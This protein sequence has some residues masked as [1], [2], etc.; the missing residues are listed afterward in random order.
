MVDPNY[1]WSESFAK[2]AQ[3][4]YIVEIPAD[5][6]ALLTEAQSVSEFVLRAQN[7]M[8]NRSNP[9]VVEVLSNIQR[10]LT[11]MDQTA[12]VEVLQQSPDKVVSPT[13]RNRT[14]GYKCES[15]VQ[16]CQLLS[17]YL[18]QKRRAVANTASG[19]G[20]IET[21]NESESL[22]L[23]L[24][25][26]LDIDSGCEFRIFIIGVHIHGEFIPVRHCCVKVADSSVQ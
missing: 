8:F 4:S 19:S 26:W 20:R 7:G 3:A 1:N 25:P 9:E 23:I 18:I 11:Q 5:F 6:V 16:V 10:H 22:H 24:R 2:H 21:E 15:T 17:S 12:F 13:N 14:R